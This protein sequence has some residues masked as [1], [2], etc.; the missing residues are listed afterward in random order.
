MHA[1]QVAV[2][3]IAALCDDDDDDDDGRNNGRLCSTAFDFA[4]VMKTAA[5]ISLTELVRAAK[6]GQTGKV[7]RRATGC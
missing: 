5:V 2:V 7:E 4:I 1:R 3:V 6:T